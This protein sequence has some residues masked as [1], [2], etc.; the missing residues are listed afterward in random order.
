MLK[1]LTTAHEA[2]RPYWHDKMV[3]YGPGGLGCYATVDA[4][5]TFQQPFEQTFDGWGDGSEV[6]IN[7]LAPTVSP[8]TGTMHS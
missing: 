2:W 6:G 7:M 4:F 1:K 5:A 3:W 8:V